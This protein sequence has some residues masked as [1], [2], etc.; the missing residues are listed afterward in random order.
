MRSQVPVVRL[1]NAQGVGQ[2]FGRHPSRAPRP[3]RAERQGQSERSGQRR[4][5]LS[6]GCSSW[7]G[8]NMDARAEETVLNAVCGLG[9]LPAGIADDGRQR[10]R[11][12]PP[13]ESAGRRTVGANRRTLAASGTGNLLG[14]SDRGGWHR[15]IRRHRR[16]GSCNETPAGRRETPTAA[17]MPDAVGWESELNAPTTTRGLER[18]HPNAVGVC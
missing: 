16:S 17:A 14:R 6:F 11:G 1:P 10:S 13:V 15:T 2:Q 4:S 18:L 9:L 8:S 5:W 12:F 3:E 7:C